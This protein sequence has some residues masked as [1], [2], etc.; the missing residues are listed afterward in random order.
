MVPGYYNQ[1][2]LLLK[3][4]F[5]QE[6]REWFRTGDLAT[7]D[8]EGFFFVKG[9]EKD[10]IIVGGENVYAGE[11]EAVLMAHTMVEEA[12]V[13][14]SEATGASSFLGEQI[15]A[16]VVPSDPTLT[17]QEF[18]RYC[19]EALPSYKVPRQFVFLEKLPRNPAGKVVKSELPL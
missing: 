14:G 15:N 1:P 10:M 7:R 9:R 17:Q 5:S 2:D 8:E 4:I 16:F 19:Y 18:R 11:V 12:A 3:S 13:K 6:G